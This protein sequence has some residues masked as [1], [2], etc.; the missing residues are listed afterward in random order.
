[1]PSG[2]TTSPIAC[3][4]GSLDAVDVDLLVL[5]WF[6]DEAPTAV[7]GL[8]A[9]TAGQLTRALAR[10][11]FRAK[12]FEVF[13]TPVSERNWRAR[14]VALV[15]AGRRSDAGSDRLRKLATLAGLVARQKQEG[16]VAFAIRGEGQVDA[17]AQ[18]VA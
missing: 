14:R 15:G 9:A 7:P 2:T 4:S 17:L 6:E 13:L 11:E 8:D 1:M 16:S 5:P 10:K 18:A 3:V 12:P